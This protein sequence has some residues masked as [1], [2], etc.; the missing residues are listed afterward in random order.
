MSP[1][2]L[3]ALLFALCLAAP[4]SSNAQQNPAPNEHALALCS[5][6]SPGNDRDVCLQV[7]TARPPKTE[8]LVVRRYGAM[9]LTKANK[10]IKRGAAMTPQDWKDINLPY[11]KEFMEGVGVP[12]W[13]SDT[14]KA[15]LA[16]FLKEKIEIK[17]NKK[18]S[19]KLYKN[20]LI[21]FQNTFGKEHPFT[22]NT[23]NELAYVLEIK[24]KY[25]EAEVLYRQNL[26][27]RKK[28][29]GD[30]HPKTLNAMNDLAYILVNQGKNEEAEVF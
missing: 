17:I 26:D 12:I 24:G 13:L 14:Q 4:L 10:A 21:R 25:K 8:C 6:F 3:P 9:G 5:D 7:C 27:L 15:T 11:F 16:N 19:E 22:L 30:E 18:N 2:T 28:V 29:L 20:Q 1:R 23:A